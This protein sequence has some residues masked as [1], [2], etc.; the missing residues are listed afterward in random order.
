MWC[1]TDIAV[2]QCGVALSYL[3][4]NVGLHRHI[5]YSTWCYIG[6][7]VIQCG[8]ALAYLLFSVVLHWHICYLMWFCTGISVIQ[9]GVTLAYLLF[10]VGFAVLYETQEFK[11]EGPPFLNLY[12]F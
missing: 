4:F 5:C 7:S 1:C 10:N 11:Q 3:L 6:I 12:I 2:I 9:C 8:F